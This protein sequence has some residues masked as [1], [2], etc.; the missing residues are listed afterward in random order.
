METGIYLKCYLDSH[1]RGNDNNKQAGLS[2][3]K[4]ETPVLQIGELAFIF[5]LIGELENRK[6]GESIYW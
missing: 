6:I 1:F 3:W 2:S 4:R 5:I